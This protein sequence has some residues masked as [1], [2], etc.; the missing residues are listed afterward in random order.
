[1]GYYTVL[2]MYFLGDHFHVN[3]EQ[4]YGVLWVHFTYILA[5]TGIQV[6]PTWL[7]F[8]ESMYTLFPK[9][10]FWCPRVSV[11]PVLLQGQSWREI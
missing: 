5:A 6:N 2:S 10:P 7:Y 4:S 11:P 3:A 8:E 9:Q 1:M